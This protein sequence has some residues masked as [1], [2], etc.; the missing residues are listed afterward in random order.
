MMMVGLVLLAVGLA[1]YR[2]N[3]RGVELPKVDPLLQAIQHRLGRPD[4]VSGSG[5]MFL[6][7]DLENGETL[8]LIVSGDRV[9][10]VDH[11]TNP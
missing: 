6:H 2:E 11:K 7:Y 1:W 4:R 8:T 5:R 9:I 10:G 3:A